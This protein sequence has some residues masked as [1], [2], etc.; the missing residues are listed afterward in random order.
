MMINTKMKKPPLDQT[1]GRREGDQERKSHQKK[2]PKR[3]PSLQVLPKLAQASGTQSSFNQFL[4]TPIDFSA[5]IMNWLKSH[6]LTQDVLTGPTYDLMKG[7]CKSVVELE[8][9]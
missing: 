5:F 1:E 2:Q 6:N 3:S 9:H 4:A 8:Y 7:M